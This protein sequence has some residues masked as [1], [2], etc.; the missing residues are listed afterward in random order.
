[1]RTRRYF[2]RNLEL[3]G[4][5]FDYDADPRRILVGRLIVGAFIGL[6]LLS[7]MLS[8][9]LSG[10]LG[11]VLLFLF[12]WA[13]VRSTAFHHRHSLY[14][15]IRFGFQAGYG[16]AFRV[17]ILGPLLTAVTLGLAYPWWQ[18]RRQAFV[19]RN[20]RYGQSHFGFDWRAAPYYG[21]WARASVLVLGIGLVLLAAVLLAGGLPGLAG[22]ELAAEEAGSNAR[23]VLLLGAAAA[24]VP[25]AL[26]YGVVQAG[27]TNLLYDQCRLEALGFRSELRAGRLTWLY[28]SSGLAVALSLGLLIPWAR[29]RLAR[30]RAERL[31]LLVRGDLDAFAQAAAPVSGLGEVASE[32][33]DAFD[34]D[35]GL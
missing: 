26:V 27:I 14:R 35:L 20:S 19:A 15:N 2:Y 21:V 3:D 33:A 29:V 13:A 22:E 4:S 11:I 24:A 30:Y 10:A 7:D 12:P 18:G 16:E 1:V 9:V 31:S 28:V 17:L 5:S 6:Y 34:F 8:T 25:F 23:A 32:A